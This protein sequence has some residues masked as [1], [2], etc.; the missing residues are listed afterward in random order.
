M[1]MCQLL[2]L[3]AG[4]FALHHIY[5]E[6]G[7]HTF[8]VE[9]RSKRCRCPLCHRLSYYVHSKYQRH[10]K[11]L[12]CFANQT[13]IHLTVHKFYC[14]NPICPQKVFTE[15]F[16]AGIG[17]YKRMT[18]RL[19]ALLTSLT[20]QL[21]GRCAERLCRLLHIEV[22]DTTLGRLL[23]KQSLQQPLTPKILGVDDWALK[24]RNRYGT[25]L[26]DL[27][28]HKIVDLLRDRETATLQR[29]LE[30]HPGVQVVSRDRYTNY[31]NAITAALPGCTQV[32]DRWH[33]LKNLCDS[34][35]AS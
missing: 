8:V 25:I 10:L 17:C 34:L 20:L 16:A 32:A 14:C 4:P 30:Q 29:W 11:D 21:S 15:R 19:S 33:L 12:P 23:Q 9:S 26:V 2:D 1:I 24:K 28:Q 6:Q 35:L 27:E 13:K 31:A 18:D 7:I 3:Q 22:S 5:V